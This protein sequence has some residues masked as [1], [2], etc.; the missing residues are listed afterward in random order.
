MIG[1]KFPE[2]LHSLVGAVLSKEFLSDDRKLCLVHS[3]PDLIVSRLQSQF[4][5][6]HKNRLSVGFADRTDL[7]VNGISD[8]IAR[9]MYLIILKLH[10]YSPS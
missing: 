7:I 2:R 6:D 9:K 5:A 8:G 4:S 10:V 1:R 3:R